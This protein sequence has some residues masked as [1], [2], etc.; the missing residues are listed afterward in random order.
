MCPACYVYVKT[1]IGWKIAFMAYMPFSN[2]DRFVAHRFDGFR[3]QGFM[4]SAT[5]LLRFAQLR[6][7]QGPRLCLYH[8]YEVNQSNYR[9]KRDACV[10]WVIRLIQVDFSKSFC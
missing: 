9:N 6:L 8:N 4:F 10:S 1:L 5:N 2:A 3:N 7:A